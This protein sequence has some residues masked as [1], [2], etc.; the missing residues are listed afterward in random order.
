MNFLNTRRGVSV[1]EPRAAGLTE[2]FQASVSEVLLLW[3]LLPPG[4]VQIA[5]R[6]ESE[7]GFTPGSAHRCCETLRDAVP[8]LKGGGHRPP[9]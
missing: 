8:L 9:A 5:G 7:R 6:M 3:C 1:P 2:G 4:K